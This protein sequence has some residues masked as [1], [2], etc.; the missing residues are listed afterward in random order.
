MARFETLPTISWVG[1][2][3]PWMLDAD[4]IY[5][6]DII[7][8]VRVPAG[9]CTDFASV[10]RLPVVYLWT[11]GRAVLP[12]IVHDYAYDCMTGIITR[13]QADAV[14]WEA[15]KSHRDPKWGITRFAMWAGV[16]LGGWRPW[17]RDS[18]DKCDI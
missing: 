2:K 13:R 11:G 4:L 16:R 17:R 18:S 3:Y 8:R 1:G 10:P 9:Y 15:M 12:S 6:S 7:G 14:F 5:H